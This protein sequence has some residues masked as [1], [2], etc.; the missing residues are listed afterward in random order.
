M[1]K[2]LVVMAVAAAATFSTEAGASSD[3]PNVIFML[4]DDLGHNDMEWNDQ[5]NQISSPKINALRQTGI[6]LD[7]YV[8]MCG[9][10]FGSQFTMLCLAIVAAGTVSQVTASSPLNEPLTGVLCKC[11]SLRF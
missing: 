1:L 11:T 3:K 2:P 6:T 9:C 8:F 10:G 4:V 7:Q 5:F